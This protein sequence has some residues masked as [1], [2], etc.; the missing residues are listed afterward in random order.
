MDIRDFLKKVDS[1]QNKDQMKEDVKRIH[2]K[3]ASQVM[4]Y[5]DTPEDMN[6][7]AQIFKNAGV[8][9]PAPV[10]GPKPE[11]EEVAA[12]EEVP[13]KGTTTPNPTYKDTKYMTKDLSGG[14]NGPKKMYKKEY[15]GDNP[16]A[17]EQEDKTSSIK[18]ELQKAYQD[19]KKKRLERKLTKPEKRKVTH[20]KKKFD[21]KGVKK[22]FIKR[23]GKEKG[24]AYMYATINKMAKKNA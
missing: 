22:D 4:L 3:E 23:Y 8:T 10:E 12:T 15:P 20:Y 5:G 1:I 18:E 24:T 9:P 21:S 7:I 11:A 17:V 16:M 13:G 6:A 19:F 14:A 2:V